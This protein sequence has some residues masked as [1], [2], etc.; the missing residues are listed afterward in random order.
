SRTL[1]GYGFEIGV[2][3]PDSGA[4]ATQK[5][6]HKLTGSTDPEGWGNQ[7]GTDMIAGL[8]AFHARRLYRAEVGKDMSQEMAWMAGTRLSNFITNGQLGLSW[9]MGANLPA[10]I[11]P[12]YAGSSS[13]IGMPG[14]LDAPG[15]GWSVFVGL[16]TEFIPYTYL[17]KQSGRY[18]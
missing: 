9:R 14:S 15:P 12:D 10:N 6:V 2:V 11:I 16:G 8:H 5:W 4:E 18:T 3:G 7:L 17:E 13:T 1:T